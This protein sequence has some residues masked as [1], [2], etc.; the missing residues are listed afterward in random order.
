MNDK[1][2]SATKLM[3]FVER[4]Q[5]YLNSDSSKIDKRLYLNSNHES[6]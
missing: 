6:D 1:T 5:I 4:R 3:S 2:I